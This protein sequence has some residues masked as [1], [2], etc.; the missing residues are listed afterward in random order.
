MNRLH[1]ESGVIVVF[2][3][4]VMTVL[5]AVAAFS[6]DVGNLRQTQRNLQ[7]AAD[8]GAMAGA[9]ELPGLAGACSAGSHGGDPTWCGTDYAFD[10]LHASRVAPTPT[11][12]SCTQATAPCTYTAGTDPQ[13]TVTQ[14]SCADSCPVT[15]ADSGSAGYTAP[16]WEITVKVCQTVNATF[17][18]IVNITSF[19]PCQQATA[20]T[21]NAT[22]F[23]LFSHSPSCGT[24]SNNDSGSGNQDSFANLSSSVGNTVNGLLRSN[25]DILVNNN[26]SENGGTSYG[27]PNQCPLTQNHAGNTFVPAPTTDFTTWNYPADYRAPTVYSNILSKCTNNV[28][29]AED[30]AQ[31]TLGSTT[32]SNLSGIWCTTGD[33]TITGNNNFCTTGCTFVGRTVTITGN[34]D[35]FS[36][37]YFGLPVDPNG[38]VIFATGPDPS[39]YSGCNSGHNGSSCAVDIQGNSNN[40]AGHAGSLTGTIFAPGSFDPATGTAINPDATI[41]LEKNNAGTVFLEAEF[42]LLQGQNTLTGSG[43]VAPGNGPQLV[44]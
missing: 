17:A 9:E 4:L 28:G 31:V 11:P 6:V 20:A 43:P 25:G 38:L 15:P 14:Y 21:R 36:P 34:G 3:A 7:A 29:G 26:F 33:I 1:D 8:A 19:H 32:G 27:G 10:T 35:V 37:A 23:A 40:G 24:G 30:T 44:G 39:G 22:R 12:T 2:V 13:V 5:L 42:L 18:R 16:T 41:N